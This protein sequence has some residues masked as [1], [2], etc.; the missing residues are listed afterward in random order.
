MGCS[1]QPVPAAHDLPDSVFIEDTAI[2]FDE[3]R[4]HRAARRRVEAARDRGGGVNRWRATVDWQFS[5][6]GDPRRRRRAA[7]RPDVYVGVSGRAPTPPASSSCANL[8]APTAIACIR[9]KRGRLLAFEE[10]GHRASRDGL[11]ARQSE[12]GRCHAVRRT[13]EVIEVDPAEP[14]AA[15]VLRIGD[16]RPVRRRHPRTNARASSAAACTSAPL[17]CRSWPRP[18]ARSR[19]AA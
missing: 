6:A 2:V 8:V 15:N 1:R 13:C 19:A 12:V 18:R 17:T 14:F 11:V 4:R 5:R 10:R 3:H 7:D 9:L 16:A